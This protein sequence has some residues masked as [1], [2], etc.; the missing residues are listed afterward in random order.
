[1]LAGPDE[2]LT[3]FSVRIRRR[4]AIALA[5]ALSLCAGVLFER[6][7]MFAGVPAEATDQFVLMSQ[8]WKTIE[9]YYVDRGAIRP[10]AMAYGAINGMTEAL[11]DTGH[12]V[13]LTPQQTKRA[14]AAMQGK[15]TGVGIEIR[16]RDRQTVV[17]A[18]IDGSP[19]Q[20]AGVRAGDVIMEVDGLPVTGLPFTQI[21]GK[22]SGL[23]G[24]P[25]EL[26]VLNPRDGQKR[27]IKIVR[28]AMKINNVSWQRLPGT[29]LAHLR[30]A[31]F[32]EGASNDFRR[33]LEEIQMQKLKGIILDLRNDPGGV[34]DEAV[35][36]ASEFLQS[37]YVLW[38][39]DAN[40]IITPVPVRPG[41][42][43]TNIP[44]ALLINGG[45]ASDS[46][47][48]AGALR[49]NHRATLIGEKTFGTG[50]VLSEFDLND[51]STLMLAVQEWLTPIKQS[52]WHRGI[53]PD[54]KIRLGPETSPLL[55]NA[56]RDITESQL[57]SS[58]DLQLRKAIE[59]L[60]SQ[61]KRGF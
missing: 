21:A 29:S 35:S 23:A 48:V 43:A 11:G 16:A 31:M 27:S 13:F 58:S 24:Q 8:A 1:M 59:V 40:S 12:S 10:N 17:V 32:N 50:T 53:E 26:T 15:L 25:V 55:P 3:L 54:I 22:I 36:I 18:P 51:G 4:Y 37:G 28:A 46:E 33:A 45:S 39:K 30:I 47:I 20:T 57:N 56:E 49:D 60:N 6:W 9:H 52:F 38:E 14:D 44:M 61:S 5:M 2:K 19:A 34:L 7:V 42:I 41:G